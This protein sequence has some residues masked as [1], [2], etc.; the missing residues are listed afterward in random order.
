M[1]SMMTYT[2][3]TSGAK[4]AVLGLALISLVNCSSSDDSTPQVTSGGS[5][6]LQGPLVLVNNTGD[7]TLT[8]VA[9][10]GDSGNAVVGTIDAAK[11]ENGALGDMQFS[12]GE[13]VFLNLGA[14]NKVAT[15][16]PLTGAQP[17]HE[18]NLVTGTNPVHIYRDSNDG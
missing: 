6:A 14:A 10:K 18:A 2:T 1:K 4:A 5:A 8:S 15:I 3:V 13:W 16:D 7:K 12:E 9:L 11:F 17:I